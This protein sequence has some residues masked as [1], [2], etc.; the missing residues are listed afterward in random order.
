MT[1]K[2]ISAD[3]IKA[4]EEYEMQLDIYNIII[5]RQKIELEIDKQDKQIENQTKRGWFSSLWYGSDGEK[6]S[7]ENTDDISIRYLKH[8][9]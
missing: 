1:T 2:K 6:K 7:D 3:I 4:C 8:V 5:I 9:I